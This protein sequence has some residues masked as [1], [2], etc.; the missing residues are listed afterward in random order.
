MDRHLFQALLVKT[1]SKELFHPVSRQAGAEVCP[2]FPEQERQPLFP[3][4]A[5]A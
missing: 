3:A 4:T 2:A 1:E 5:V